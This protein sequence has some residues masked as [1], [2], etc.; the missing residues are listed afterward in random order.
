MGYS[1]LLSWKLAPKHFVL[2]KPVVA[3]SNFISFNLFWSF[4]SIFVVD[5]PSWQG[6]MSQVTKGHHECTT[7]IFNPMVPLNSETSGAKV[8]LCCGTLTF[9]QPLCLKANRIKHSYPDELISI[10]LRAASCYKELWERVY[11]KHS[12][13]KMMTG[14]AHTKCLRAWFLTDAA[15]HLT[16]MKS[17]LCHQYPEVKI[18]EVDYANISNEHEA[19]ALDSEDLEVDIHMEEVDGCEEV[20][21]YEDNVLKTEKLNKIL[22]IELVEK[23]KAQ[24][25]NLVSEDSNFDDDE[26]NNLLKGHGN[27]NNAKESVTESRTASLWLMFMELVVCAIAKQFIRA[28]RTGDWG[29]HL[30]STYD[31]LPYFAA[32]GHS[33]YTKYARL[34]YQEFTSLFPCL[35]SKCHE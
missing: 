28:E 21:G 11:A 15:L 6:F 35:S 14:K 32:A 2:Q 1:G 27:F 7:V 33:N 25:S 23:L 29:L 30:K 34:Y 5:P 10:H 24:S 13:P 18:M 31:M 17:F 16:L 8:G 9:D 26:F 20:K 19:C 4:S 3:V 12:I 22:P